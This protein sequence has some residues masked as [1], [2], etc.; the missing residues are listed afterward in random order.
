M[1]SSWTLM[2]TFWFSCHGYWRD[3]YGTVALAGERSP[4]DDDDLLRLDFSVPLERVSVS[5][6]MVGVYLPLILRDE[7]RFPNGPHY[8]EELDWLIALWRHHGQSTVEPTRQGWWYHEAGGWRETTKIVEHVRDEQGEYAWASG[9][10]L[11]EAERRFLRVLA[12][13]GDVDPWRADTLLYG[14]YFD[15]LASEHI[16]RHLDGGETPVWAPPNQRKDRG[17][18]KLGMLGA[19]PRLDFAAGYRDAIRP[20]EAEREP[21][22]LRGPA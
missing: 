22:G 21:A 10:A 19:L 16:R 1:S 4:P 8:A 6:D 17:A 18:S 13:D 11:T 14:H 12:P 5:G 15:A 3:Q 9:V 20:P 2:A 7:R